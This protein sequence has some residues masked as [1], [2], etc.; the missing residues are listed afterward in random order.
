MDSTYI[1]DCSG[2][3]LNEIPPSFPETTNILLLTNNKITSVADNSFFDCTGLKLLDM[4]VNKLDKITPETFADLL[5]LETL[6][7]GENNI[8]KIESNTFNKNEQMI[9]L[10]ISFNSLN[11]LSHNSL[12]GISSL[13]TLLLANNNIEFD[14]LDNDTFIDL[15][16]L[17][18][19]TMHGNAW[20]KMDMYPDIL[21]SSLYHVKNLTIDGLPGNDKIFGPGF[22]N[23]HALESLYIYGGFQYVSNDT[24]GV[25]SN[26]TVKSLHFRSAEL[27]DTEEMAFSHFS[28]LEILDFTYNPKLGFD[29]ASRSWYGLQYTNVSTIYL[30]IAVPYDHEV[31]TME[32]SFFK[33]LNLTQI[34]EMKLD[35][36]NMV[37]MDSHFHTEV[38]QIVN[39]TYS[40]NRLMQVLSIMVDMFFCKDLKVLDVSYQVRRLAPL[41]E[42]DTYEEWRTRVKEG[43]ILGKSAK[44][45]PTMLDIKEKCPLIDEL[46]SNILN[47]TNK[48]PFWPPDMRTTSP[49]PN[50]GPFCIPVPPSLEEFHAAG[51]L[52]VEFD[53]MGE[54]I[55]LGD[56]NVRIL[57]YSQ[58]AIQRFLGPVYFCP[59]DPHLRMS[60][61]LSL[62][63]AYEM[64]PEFSQYMGPY[65][66]SFNFAFNDLGEQLRIDTDGRTFS[67]VPY[68]E[69]LDLTA[70]GIKNLPRDVF[71]HLG[72]L[73]Y[74]ILSINALRLLDLNFSHHENLTHL[75]LAE[76]LLTSL[77]PENCH[78]LDSLTTDHEFTLDLSGNPLECSCLTISFMEWMLATH[79]IFNNWDE[80]LCI[81]DGSLML[82]N[83]K[84]I[85]ES[86][87]NLSIECNDKTWLI[88]VSLSC[89]LL[90]LI[91]AGSVL[92][93][94]HRWE[95]TYC[96]NRFV[97]RRKQYQQYEQQQDEIWRYDAFIAHDKADTL[98]VKNVL[99]PALESPDRN[100]DCLKL[101]IHQRDFNIGVNIQESI[102]NAVCQSRKTLLVISRKYLASSWC[103]FETEI[104]SMHCFDQGRDLIVSIRMEDLPKDGMPKLLKNLLRRYTYIDYPQGAC[105]NS[106]EMN[107]FWKKLRA[108]VQRPPRYITHCACGRIVEPED[109]HQEAAL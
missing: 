56:S 7:I 106:E 67:N 52:S 82:M 16:H 95:I 42:S 77:S 1:V 90:A 27:Y 98:F 9:F 3:S 81:Y 49:L 105:E 18:L 76:N 99:G 108:A 71:Q 22:A 64:T 60:V 86:L 34:K 26:S 40:Y 73:T 38:S 96:C 30:E 85:T 20:P 89:V 11:N 107:D 70:N 46:L 35:G 44:C 100:G 2:L 5:N 104:A 12:R 29:N 102:L 103:E 31:I 79:V 94:R 54:V 91:I 55:L 28:A 17:E 47:N 6:F 25:F 33:Y 48:P 51:S 43:V 45:N 53:T 97:L 4:A 63:N 61:D 50:T 10:D 58:N 69:Y 15:K 37:T 101:C 84:N 109:T 59:R 23:M 68:M 72:S 32:K 80:Y 83:E 78:D 21:L 41:T 24:F 87:Q 19:L 62:N 14:K 65:V 92:M 75:S 57:D 39:L 13:K 36:N 66:R 74:L 93:F 88:V 8:S